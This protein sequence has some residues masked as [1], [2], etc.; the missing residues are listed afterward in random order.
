VQSYSFLV[1]K[2]WLDVLVFL[3]TTQHTCQPNVWRYHFNISILLMRNLI[4]KIQFYLNWK[5]MA[6]C[7][8]RGSNPI[9]THEG[10]NMF[11]S[12]AREQGPTSAS[13]N[14]FFLI[15]LFFFF[16]L[17]GSQS[18]GLLSQWAWAKPNRLET[19]QANTGFYL[20]SP[21]M[22]VRRPATSC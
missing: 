5:V 20:F 11:T 17:D 15:S 8:Q 9:P 1:Y 6:E 3:W 22:K 7:E 12:R 4:H 14:T 10:E 2:I 21:V 16:S 13:L 19:R 18:V